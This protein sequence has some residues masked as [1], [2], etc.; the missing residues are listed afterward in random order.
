MDAHDLLFPPGTTRHDWVVDGTLVAALLLVAMPIFLVG[1]AQPYTLAYLVVNALIVIPLIWRRHAPLIALA[2]VTIAGIIHLYTLDTPTPSLVAIPII[3]YS[4]ARW[5]SGHWSRIAVAIG[6][7]GSVL[8]PIRWVLGDSRY[9]SMQ[10]LMSLVLAFMVCLGLVVTPYAIGRRVREASI[11]QTHMVAQADERYHAL[12]IERDQQARLAESRARNQIARELHDIVAH[13]LS[14]MIVQAEGGR[15]AAAK[16]PEAATNALTTIADTGREALTEMRRI[17]GV[18]RADPDT[19]QSAEFAPAPRLED[20]PDLV[21]HTSDR[22]HLQVNGRPP[23]VSQVMELTVYR[24]VQE[25][26]TNFLKHAGSDATAHVTLTYGMHAI[27]VDVLDDGVGDAEPPHESGHGLRGMNERVS[28]MGGRLIARPRPQPHHG[29][30]VTAV[31]PLLGGP[32]PEGAAHAAPSPETFSLTPARET[33][34]T[35][36]TTADT[37]TSGAPDWEASHDRPSG[38]HPTAAETSA[39]WA[40]DT[41]S[42]AADSDHRPSDQKGLS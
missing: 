26:L 35:R 32:P 4:V 9:M 13:S 33:P 7:F 8:G 16:H 40:S 22:A 2:G 38:T 28:A 3:V 14:V 23:H 12:M 5:V 34:G 18:L 11:A 27:T 21:G 1:Y 10:Q 15:A 37:T 39:S 41:S 17:L 29:F 25:A 36:P 30:Q 6:G 31:L 42:P 19:E 24:V 20:I